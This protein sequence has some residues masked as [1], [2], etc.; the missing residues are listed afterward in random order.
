MSG[1]ERESGRNE[2]HRN[3]DGKWHRNETMQAGV[4]PENDPEKYSY[5]YSYSEDE[6]EELREKA[7]EA[8]HRRRKEER[9]LLKKVIEESPRAPPPSKTEVSKNEIPRNQKAVDRSVSPR[10]RPPSKETIRK[11]EAPVN[12]KASDRPVHQQTRPGGSGQREYWPDARASRASDKRK[13]IGLSSET[14]R[15]RSR[16]IKNTRGTG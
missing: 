2:T 3:A 13:T 10:T 16:R 1:A 14:S 5:S 8:A 9:A 11:S 4:T 15:T 7:V 6:K 12:Q